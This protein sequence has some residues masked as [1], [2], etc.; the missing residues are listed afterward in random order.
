MNTKLFSFFK[1]FVMLEFSALD[2]FNTHQKSHVSSQFPSKM[3]FIGP[4]P[5]SIKRYRIGSESQVKFLTAAALFT[6]Y[7]LL[8]RRVKGPRAPNKL[9]R[10]NETGSIWPR[11][12]RGIICE[13][14]GIGRNGHAI[15][16]LLGWLVGW[17]NP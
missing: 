6:S 3:W 16:A 17:W 7:R 8:L 13:I 9:S 4:R 5:E 15:Q 2:V 14:L 1:Y 12:P 11:N 10:K